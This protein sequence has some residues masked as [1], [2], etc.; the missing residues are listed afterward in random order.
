VELR[1][2]V[3]KSVRSGNVKSP[4]AADLIDSYQVF[5]QLHGHFLGINTILEHAIL[6]RDG[7]DGQATRL[8]F[9]PDLC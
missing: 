6:V 4:R 2:K 5:E 9:F 7:D 1:Y 8:V 3:M